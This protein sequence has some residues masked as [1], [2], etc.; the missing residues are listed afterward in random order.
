MLS[1]D[2]HH[3]VQSCF[4]YDS[5]LLYLF[6]PTPSLF[7]LPSSE[8]C[9]TTWC[10][11]IDPLQHPRPSGLYPVTK[12]RLVLFWS[13]SC[14][15]LRVHRLVW[16]MNFVSSDY[17]CHCFSGRFT[18]LCVFLTVFPFS[19]ITPFWQRSSVRWSYLTK[20]FHTPPL[21]VGVTGQI[22]FP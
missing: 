13:D 2:Q 19:P 6:L 21:S 1:S 10:S 18:S 3:R 11:P 12:S 17:L 22:C 16:L 20:S 4:T 15:F 9:L 7:L 8:H 14:S 5:P